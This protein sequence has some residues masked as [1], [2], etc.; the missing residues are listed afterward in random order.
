MRQISTHLRGTQGRYR[1]PFVCW[2]GHG[3]SGSIAG[4]WILTASEMERTNGSSAL[5]LKQ[6]NSCLNNREEQYDAKNE[7]V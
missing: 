1:Y 5:N 2:A 7:L 6:R 4:Q 3:S